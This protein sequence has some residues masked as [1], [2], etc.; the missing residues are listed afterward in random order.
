M[1]CRTMVKKLMCIL[2]SWVLFPL[3]LV[4][5]VVTVCGKIYVSIG[6]K[7]YFSIYLN[8][9]ITYHLIK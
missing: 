4:D 9:K 7:D 3:S 5:F 1:L 8:I 6:R 2:D